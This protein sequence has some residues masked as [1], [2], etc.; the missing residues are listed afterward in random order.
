MRLKKLKKQAQAKYDYNKGSR[1]GKSE[2]KSYRSSGNWEL[3]KRKKEGTYPGYPSSP[4]Y[5]TKTTSTKQHHNNWT[6][7]L[8]GL[9]R[10]LIL[11]QLCLHLASIYQYKLHGVGK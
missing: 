2:T 7:G 4:D 5:W 10:T 9:P 1:V 8:S 6:L 11:I 3:V